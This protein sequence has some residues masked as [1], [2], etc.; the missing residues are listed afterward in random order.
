MAKKRSARKKSG[1]FTGF[2]FRLIFILLL[3]GAAAGAA[4][5]YGEARKS[6]KENQ[7]LE[8]RIETLQTQ[9]SELKN[10]IRR[11]ADTLKEKG[12]EVDE[13]KIRSIIKTRGLD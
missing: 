1:G 2:L 3:C 12:E 13:L 9:N 10:E 8:N 7:V 4:Y 11:M 5:F 6:R